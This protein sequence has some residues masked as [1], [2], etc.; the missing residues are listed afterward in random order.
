[1]DFYLPNYGVGIECQ[2]IQHFIENHFFEPIEVVKER[3]ERKRKLC[4]EHGIKLLYYSNLGIK[5]PYEVF[6]NK[7]KILEEIKKYGND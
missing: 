6:E 7:E 1:M 2:G 4:E 3:D 5:Y